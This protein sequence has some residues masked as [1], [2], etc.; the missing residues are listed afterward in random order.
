MEKLKELRE[1]RGYTQDELA[2]KIGLSKGTISSYE[3]GLR[4][5][6]VSSAKKLGQV[7]GVEWHIFFE[8]DVSETYDKIN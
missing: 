8:N 2:R 7:L 6:T 4:G 3:Q 1:S 5:I